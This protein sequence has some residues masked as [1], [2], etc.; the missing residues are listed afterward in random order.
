[1][2]IVAVSQSQQVLDDLRRFLVVE[3]SP[4]EV[5]FF[6][7]S[8]A[9]AGLAVEQNHPNLLVFDAAF[10]GQ[11][12]LAELELITLRY[13]GMAV[14]L[15]SQA[16]S[17]EFLTEAMR[18]GV[19]EVLPLPLSSQ[20]LLDAVFRAQKRTS[21]AHAPTRKGK[22]LTFIACKGGSGA[23]FLAVN[24]GYI[25]ASTSGKRVALLDLNL[26]FGNASLFVSDHAPA[27][28]I[29]DVASNIQRLD[30]SL[31]ASSMVQILPNF[32]VLAAPESP[33]R[34]SEI[35]PE[36][37]D[38]LIEL[39]T[40][41]YDFVI[42]DMSRTLDAVSVRALDRADML[43]PV[44]QETLPFIRDAKRLLATFKSLGYGQE[45]IQ[46]VVNRYEKGGD[47]RLEDVEST[48]GMKVAHTIPNSFKAVSA[49]VNQGVPVM[50]IAPHDTV[51]KALMQ[52]AKTLTE[53]NN[54]K[55]TGWLA[56]VFNKA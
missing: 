54:V 47:I 38:A 44:L 7:G 53:L 42:L 31:L 37:L 29:A 34:A 20:A 22:V 56:R 13:P 26:H 1:M 28:T 9:Q 35:K 43:F 51:T 32:G 5:S 49:S 21:L 50:K 17:P 11:T 55:Q 18:V 33:E 36:H 3:K 23:T 27:N 15:L 40:T 6:T 19:R 41:H 45:K 39:A 12:Q 8:I 48:L 24:L 25:L 30:A 46:L 52:W 4:F 16:N 2:K 14:I 10:S